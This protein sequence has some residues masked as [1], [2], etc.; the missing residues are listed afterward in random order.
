MLTECIFV[1]SGVLGSGLWRATINHVVTISDL[2]WKEDAIIELEKCAFCGKD[3]DE[4]EKLIKAPN[5]NVCICDVCARIVFNLSD[6]SINYK[7]ARQRRTELAKAI[8]GAGAVK[9]GAATT[10]T[11]IHRQLD[12]YIIGQ[13]KAKKILTV[14]V[15]NHSKRLKDKSGLIKKSNILLIGPTGCGKTLL[16]STLAKLLDVPFAMIDASGLTESGYVGDDVDICLHRLLAAADGD[17][18]LAQKGIIYIDEIDKIACKNPNGRDIGG[19]SVQAELLKLIEGSEVEIPADGNRRNLNA[20]FVTMDTTDILFIC[21]G[22]FDGITNNRKKE[23]HN[24]GFYSGDYRQES[25][26]GNPVSAEAIVK[27]GMMPELV[28]RLPIFCTLDDLTENDLI[29][30]LTE[31]EDAI[32]KEYELLLKK[33]SVKLVFQQ[34]ALAEIAKTAIRRKTG[35]R[36]LRSILESIM[37]D[38]MY[39]IP[40]RRDIS[41]CVVTAECIKSGKP[42]LIK[43]SAKKQ[44]NGG[45]G[46]SLKTGQE[47]GT[48]KE[49]EGY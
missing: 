37:L 28:G 44:Q 16:A 43:K 14:A 25:V 46:A 13:E 9:K 30:I 34:D 2:I 39:E 12:R 49:Q 4:V 8:V 21:G 35:A 24:I 7:S 40:G 26:T 19:E 31:P 5:S 17:V 6:D 20:K 1:L 18:D 10:P 42:L 48:V 15:Y 27:Y 3:I 33:D 22:A 11:E 41:K 38:V 29:R 36:G 32:V 23:K 47:K 45:P